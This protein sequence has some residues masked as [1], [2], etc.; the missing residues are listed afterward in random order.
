MLTRTQVMSIRPQLVRVRLGWL[1]VSEPGSPL[2]I[3]VQAETP[4]EA[5]ASFQRAL[6]SWAALCEAPLPVSAA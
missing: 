6:G 5:R 3:G 4:E 1:A 2:G